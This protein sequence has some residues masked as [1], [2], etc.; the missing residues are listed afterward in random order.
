MG[1]RLED[2]F[3]LGAKVLVICNLDC[4]FIMSILSGIKTHLFKKEEL[5]Y[6][7]E[8]MFHGFMV[9]TIQGI[10]KNELHNAFFF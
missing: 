4:N 3:F 8:Y 9:R 6:Q 7:R 5:K 10:H 1:R 2:N